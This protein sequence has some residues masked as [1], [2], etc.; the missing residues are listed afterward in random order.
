MKIP[1]GLS[2]APRVFNKFVGGALIPLR[3]VRVLHASS[4]ERYAFTGVSS[5]EIRFQNKPN[6][7]LSNSFTGDRLPGSQVK[8]VVF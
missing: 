7:E 6:K 3:N 5:G 8:S 4:R 2:Q 1:I